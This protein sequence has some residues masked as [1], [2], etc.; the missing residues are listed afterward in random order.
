[1]RTATLVRTVTSAILIIATAAQPARLHAQIMRGT[2][3]VANSERP[4]ENAKITALLADGRSV[5]SATTDEKGRFHLI[6][7]AMGQ[8]FT[9]VITRIGMRPAESTPLF[10]AARDTLD[11][12]FNVTEEAIVADTMKIT[13][14][15]ALNEIRLREAE[16]RGWKVFPPLEIQAIRERV[17]SFEDLLRSTGF[18]GLIIPSRRNECIRSTRQNACIAIVVDGVVI[19]PGNSLINPKDVYF[20]ALLSPNQAQ[21]EFG[22]RALHGALVVQTRAY[23]DR[24]DR[25]I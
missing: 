15:P 5:G 24:Y 17:N 8:A 22:D 20:V 16:R 1:M 19:A 11:L 18:P 7:S 10:A 9:V 2:A 14:A 3:R 12:D 13:A 21:L 4:L 6:V 23:G 25:R